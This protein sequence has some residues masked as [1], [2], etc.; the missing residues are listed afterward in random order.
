MSCL[1]SHPPSLAPQTFSNICHIHS[2][3]AVALWQVGDEKASREER[4]G[5][6]QPEQKATEAQLKMGSALEKC[7]PPG[8]HGNAK[9][10][11]AL[12]LSVTWDFELI[13]LKS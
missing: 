7:K 10:G 8:I 4:L 11:S 9:R 2:L 13:S 6:K 1:A 12:P 3:E 5:R